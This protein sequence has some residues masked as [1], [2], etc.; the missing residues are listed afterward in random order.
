VNIWRWNRAKASLS[1][2][3]EFHLKM[4]VEER[5]ARG[6]DPGQ[7][8]AAALRQFGNLPLIKDVTRVSWGWLWLENL[9]HDLRHAL[10]QLRR[11]PAF[12]ATALLTLA[13]GIGANLGVFQ[14]LYAVILSDLPVPHPDEIVAVHVAQ[15]PFDHDWEVSYPAYQRLRA[16]TPDIPL[17]A[18]AYAGDATVEILHHASVKAY[19]RLVSS[20]YFSGLGV[21]PAAGRLFVQADEQQGQGEWPAVLRYDFARDMFGSVQQAVGQHMQLNGQ[22]FVVIGVAHKRFLGD[23]NGYPPA[24]WIPLEL[25]STGKLGV[26]W[27]SLGPGHDVFLDKPWYNQSTIFWLALTARIPQDRRAAVLA[28]WDQVFRSDREVMTEATPDPEARAALLRVRSEAVPLNSGQGGIRKK[29]TAPLTLLMALSASIFLVGCLNLA[30]LQLARLQ[31]RALEFGIRIALGASRGRLLRKVILEDTLLVAAGSAL[32]FGLGRVASGI[33]VRW[34]SSRN[35]DITLDLHV[36]LPLAA[37]G[38]G[39]MVLSLLC[40]SVLPAIIFIRTGAAQ[41]TGSRAKVAGVAQTGRQRWRSDLLLGAQVSLSLLLATMSGCFAATLMHFETIDV[42]MDRDHVLIVHPELNSPQY[43]EGSQKLLGLYQQIQERLQALPGVRNVAVGMCANIH[44]GWN[45]ALYVHGQAGLTDAQVH[46]QEDHVGLGYF[47][48]LGIPIVRG[49]DFATSDTERTQPVAI[50][51]HAYAHQ[52][53]GDADPIGQ[54][55]GY[56]PAPNDHKFIIVGEVADARVNGAKNDPPPLVYMSINQHPSPVNSIRV[57]AIGDPSQ[58]TRSVRQVLHELDPSMKID[59][60]VPLSADLDGDL[61][62]EKLLA[63]LAGIY[64]SLTLLLVGIGFYGVMSSRTTRRKNEF[65]IRLALGA[66]RQHIMMLVVGQTV[67]ILLAGIVPGAIL[68]IL[69]VRAASHF[70][71]GTVSANLLAIIAASLVLMAAGSIATLIPAQRAALAEPLE[72]LRG[73]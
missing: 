25:Q 69:A 64:A 39:L 40:F 68:S 73:E 23:V 52:L 1:E 16:S 61:G 14:I 21:T 70:L 48:T 7:A 58:L 8:R 20:N 63:R 67:G 46:G 32:A 54:S 47:A 37:L 53:F 55:V 36:N 35:A 24:M 29:F 60:I 72:T 22:A 71:Y 50:I 12:T 38:A 56:G 65:G 43:A 31:A 3:L 30:N 33:L 66:T 57:G 34:A 4:E 2:E 9:L 27:D 28:H 41:A 17:I 45:T 18:T 26:A 10:R 59:E 42:G 13:F 62:T 11:A 49:R 15:S 5:V 51:N 19:C 44:C 6:E